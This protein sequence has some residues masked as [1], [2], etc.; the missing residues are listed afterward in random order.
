[1][2]VTLRLLLPLLLTLRVDEPQFK[3]TC[4]F[5]A[6]PGWTVT[7]WSS[8]AKWTA[9]AGHADLGMCLMSGEL[10]GDQLRDDPQY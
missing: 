4:Q 10:V 3:T 5:F 2:D 1:M 8:L 6:M 7:S 9:Q